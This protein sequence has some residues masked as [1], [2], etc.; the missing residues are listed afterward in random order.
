MHL[1]Q[2]GLGAALAAVFITTFAF[3]ASV[4][5]L[6]TAQCD[7]LEVH[8]PDVNILADA[9][10]LSSAAASVNLPG[11]YENQNNIWAFGNRGLSA[12]W[13]SPTSSVAAVVMLEAFNLR[14]NGGALGAPTQVFF[15]DCTAQT[16]PSIAATLR[17]ASDST[18]VVGRRLPANGLPGRAGL[19]DPLIPIAS[20]P[21]LPPSATPLNTPNT[22]PIVPLPAPLLLLLGALLSLAILRKQAA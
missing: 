18:L 3:G 12:V 14:R 5:P 16:Q 19:F 10:P 4:G 22:L 7:G 21:P 13:H 11:L 17:P 15:A 9:A 6:D 1:F 8:Q 2:T 20:D